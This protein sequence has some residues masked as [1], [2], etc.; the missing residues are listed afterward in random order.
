MAK[1]TFTLQ[2][3][4]PVQ[5]SGKT[6]DQY[7]YKHEASGAQIGFHMHPAKAWNYVIV[8]AHT[9]DAGRKSANKI[10]DAFSIALDAE[11]NAGN[12]EATKQLT[13]N[14]R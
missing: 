2:S 9:N 12:T 7:I 3:I 10:I 6:E 5:Y 14:V 4:T 13:I 11:V 8:T 1:V